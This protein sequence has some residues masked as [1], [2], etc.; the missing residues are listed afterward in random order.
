VTQSV[1]PSR[2][3]RIRRAP[4][5]VGSDCRWRGFPESPNRI[6]IGRGH[7][8]D[9]TRATVDFPLTG[10]FNLTNTLLALAACEAVSGVPFRTL[11]EAVPDLHAPRGRLERVPSDV[12][13]PRVLVDY[14]HTPDALRRV[15]QAARPIDGGRLITVFGCGGDRDRTKRPLMRDAACAVSDVVILTS[16]NPR[17]EDPQAIAEDVMRGHT[18]RPF[19]VMLD[20]AE[21]IHHAIAMAKSVDT[22]LIAGKGHEDYQVIADPPGAFG[23]DTRTVHFNDVEV[24]REALLK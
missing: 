13:D 4:L 7:G 23:G 1:P 22:V 24:A 8:N 6:E 3:V 2:I 18:G 17:S 14:A 15:T 11:V 21:A 10:D 16:D 12:G 19:T 5:D 20:R 9:S